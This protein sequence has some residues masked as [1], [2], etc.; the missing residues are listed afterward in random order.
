MLHGAD[1]CPAQLGRPVTGQRLA[2]RIPKRRVHRHMVERS[3]A[4][5]R[6][7]RNHLCR[8]VPPMFGPAG[9][10]GK[11]SWGSGTACP[12]ITLEKAS[13]I[14]GVPAVHDLADFRPPGGESFRDLQQ[15]VLPQIARIAEETAGTACIVTHAGVI[16]VLDLPRAADAAC[17][18]YFEFVSIT[19]A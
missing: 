15:R 13:P 14:S 19:E 9:N 4:R 6:N 16:R 5:N 12:G 17:R 7:R 2:E 18:I 1:G 3:D 11:S 10:C 8:A